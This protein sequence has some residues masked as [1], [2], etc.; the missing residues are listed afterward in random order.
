SYADATGTMPLSNEGHIRT[1]TIL[2]KSFDNEKDPQYRE[3]VKRTLNS[4]L[5]RVEQSSDRDSELF[6]VREMAR[7]VLAPDKK[8]CALGAEAISLYPSS[9]HYAFETARCYAALGDFDEA[10]RVI[11]RA[12]PYFKAFSASG[13]PQGLFVYKIKDLHA[14]IEYKKGNTD[15]AIAI[16]KGNLTDGMAGKYAIYNAKARELWSKELLIQY[17]SQK[18]QFYEKGDKKQ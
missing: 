6:F 2:L 18:V 8:A 3:R 5:Q 12:E 14:D 4:H 10:L 17:L 11:S 1:I 15:K 9:A 13:N 7:S 16:E